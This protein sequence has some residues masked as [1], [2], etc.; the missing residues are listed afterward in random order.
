MT[1][2]QPTA[3]AYVSGLIHR[4]ACVLIPA[5]ARV[6]ETQ[7]RVTHSLAP[8]GAVCVVIGQSR[9]AAPTA[10]L[11]SAS[12]ASVSNLNSWT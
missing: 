11:A 12:G 7:A 9:P 8:H 2:V 5:G 4:D 1:G 10:P 6:A 3:I